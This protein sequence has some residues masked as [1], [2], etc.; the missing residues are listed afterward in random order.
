MIRTGSV[1]KLVNEQSG[2]NG[3]FYPAP[4]T[5]GK[6]MKLINRHLQVNWCTNTYPKVLWCDLEDVVEVRRYERR[7]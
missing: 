3:R 1:V 7:N 6:V 4:G 5:Y 2:E